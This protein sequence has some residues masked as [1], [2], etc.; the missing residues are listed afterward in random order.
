MAHAPTTTQDAAPAPV[1]L[2]WDEVKL[3]GEQEYCTV[4]HAP[5][6]SSKAGSFRK[7]DPATNAYVW[8]DVWCAEA[9]ASV[10]LDHPRQGKMRV[11]FRGVE[12]KSLREIFRCPR[13]A[14][15]YSDLRG[16]GTRRDGSSFG[17]AYGDVVQVNGYGLR[18]SAR[19][20]GVRD[21]ATGK[22]KVRPR[23]Q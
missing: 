2:L 17:F 12:R 11:F 6:T 3:L 16:R 10:S 21:H 14:A 22:V 15:G 7:H 5:A 1:P 18:G 8:I 19:V 9:T 23:R 4:V 20:T 13:E